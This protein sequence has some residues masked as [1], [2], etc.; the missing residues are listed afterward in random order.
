MVFFI[1]ILLWV[2]WASWIFGL[3]IFI[4]LKKCLAIRS[5]NIFFL[6]YLLPSETNSIH[7]RLLYSVPQVIFFNLF[8]VSMQFFVSVQFFQSFF[9]SQCLILHSSLAVYLEVNLLFFFFSSV[10]P[11]CFYISD[12]ALFLISKSCIQALLIS[13]AFLFMMITYYLPF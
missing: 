11:V 1:F 13:L 4:K 2:C 8:S 7:I 12:Y 6:P 10:S 5:S 3:I 9:L